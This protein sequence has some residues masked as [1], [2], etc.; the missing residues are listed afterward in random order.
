MMRSF[1]SA[2]LLYRLA[3]AS[4]TT[5][6]ESDQAF[7]DRPCN[8]AVITD[9]LADA[10]SIAGRMNG[11]VANRANGFTAHVGGLS[12]H[13]VVVAAGEGRHRSRLDILEAV[14]A[15]HR[16]RLIVG[17][18]VC[19]GIAAPA[20]RNAV[21][22]AHEVVDEA[23]KRLVLGESGWRPR[24]GVSGTVVSLTRPV[25]SLAEKQDVARRFQAL[26]VDQQSFA[27]AEICAAE[28]VPF[29][30]LGVVLDGPDEEMPRDIRFLLERKSPAGK[31]GAFAGT[32]FRSPSHLK[33][34]WRLKTAALEAGEKMADC[35]VQLAQ[36]LPKTN[37]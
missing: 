10:E 2:K 34:L 13:Q 25:R 36:D 12:G 1:R 20:V 18:G 3:Q 14:L 9:H 17:A 8:L 33:H 30:A 24:G 4:M 29:L 23:G 7:D 19:S 28:N 15:A 22:V 27:L 37:E 32:L 21:V 26:A 6:Q 35:V 5:D 16:P 31:A 11:S